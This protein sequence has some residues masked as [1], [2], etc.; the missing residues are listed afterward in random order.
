MAHLRKLR[1]PDK[2]EVWVD[3]NGMFVAPVRS[4]NSHEDATEHE[5]RQAAEPFVR[6][7]GYDPDCLRRPTDLRHDFDLAMTDGEITLSIEV[8]GLTWPAQTMAALDKSNEAAFSLS[9]F[10]DEIRKDIRKANQQLA[11]AHGREKVILVVWGYEDDPASPWGSW[12]RKNIVRIA[13]DVSAEHEIWITT[14]RAF[15]FDRLR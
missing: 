12:L 4:N 14:P 15:R 2:R 8:K 7:R 1:L 3:R 13:E 5:E 9:Q 11:D 10:E 6:F